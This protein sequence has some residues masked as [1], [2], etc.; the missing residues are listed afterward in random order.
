[1]VRPISV[2][3]RRPTHEIDLRRPTHEIDLAYPHRHI[4]P[5]YTTIC[6]KGLVRLC[7]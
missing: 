1:M 2:D 6:A 3:R 7:R 4:L 5:G